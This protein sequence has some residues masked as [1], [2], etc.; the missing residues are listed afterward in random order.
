MNS[1]DV[2]IDISTTATAHSLDLVLIMIT[3]LQLSGAED[4]RDGAATPGGAGYAEAGEG[5]S[6][7]SGGEAEQC[8]QES[9]VP[10]EPRHRKQHCP[11][12]TTAGDDGHGPQPAEPVLQGWRWDPNQSYTLLSLS[13]ILWTKEIKRKS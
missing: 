4:S 7:G 2:F 10:A 3:F 12:K 6:P 5:K 13:S 8:H 9:G 1:N 11:A